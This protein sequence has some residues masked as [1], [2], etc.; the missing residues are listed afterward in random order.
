MRS[1][2]IHR[3]DER[4]VTAVGIV[5]GILAALSPASPTGSG[6]A[7]AVLVA[8]SV[9][10]VVWAGA[11][12]RWWALLA[13]AVVATAVAG[14]LV[15]VAVGACTVLAALWIGTQQRDLSIVR[16]VVAAVSANV[17]IRSDVGW[18]L[19][20]TLFLVA[21]ASAL[22]VVSGLRRRRRAVQRNTA[23]AAAVLG[24][25]VAGTIAASLVAGLTAGSDLR[26][27]VGHVRDGV[28]LLQD[29]EYLAASERFDLAAVELSSSESR[30]SSTWASPASWVP[31]VAQQR[32][33]MTSLAAA[34]ADAS[35]ELAAALRL[36]DPDQLRLVGGRFDLDAIRLIEQP[37]SDVQRSI[38][39]LDA[40]VDRAR[41]PWLVAPIARRL[42]ELDEQLDDNGARL[43]TAVAAVR[44]APQ[45]LGA[46][47]PRRYFLAFTTPTE[48]RGT[49]G[50]MG[51]WAVLTAD[52]GRIRLS[53]FGRTRELNDGG[54]AGRIVSG[55]ADWL[56]QWGRYGFTTG[57]GGSTDS[58]PWSRIT[59]SPV[60][61]STSQVIHE[62]LPQ[63]G[64]RPVDGVFS[65]DPTVLRALLS[66]TGPVSV[67]GSNVRL[68]ESNV[69]Q[70]LLVDQYVTDEV[71]DAG[72][73]DDSGDAPGSGDDGFDSNEERIDFLEDVAQA[74]IRGVLAGALP[75]P[76]VV[77]RE[78]GPVIEQGRLL[79]TA[80]DP[81][82]QELFESI[83]LSGSLPSLDGGDGIAAVFN[84]A[85]PN[86]IDTYLGREFTYTAEVDEQ[87]GVVRSELVLTLTNDADADALPDSVVDNYTGDPR[88][89]NRTLLSLYSALPLVEATVDG[90]PLAMRE[91]AEDGWIVNTA[92]LGIP[93]GGSI[94]VTAQYRGVL[95]LD[96]GYTLA[97]RP[98]PIV[99]PERR[100]VEVTSDR[101]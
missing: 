51:N 33:A 5:G 48:T 24:V 9:G 15:L 17:A 36:V 55:P 10:F 69:L 7:D 40:Q 65:L 34:A 53:E 11:T 62:L 72:N 14:S 77:A 2:R 61:E 58:T 99:V 87:T 52:D 31:V 26:N 18:F 8:A 82:V 56:E 100:T 45:I 6:G 21:G 86:K 76:A 32:N 68:D 4:T 92:F 73:D 101:W 57:P 44:L 30:L 91:S 23:I 74:T 66:L 42:E 75:S 64:R 81:A 25:V 41:S 19:G 88:G 78:L 89:T 29:G 3:V 95:E 84:N 16:A 59:I 49:G 71:T 22:V 85:A 67:D 47:G 43:D 1:T 79:G 97:V 12:A 83:G 13:L 93:P 37:L 39:E 54:E 98:Q 60:F 28:A 27:G 46:D 63:S 96:G 35:D 50:F 80:T 38:D 94:T 70:F 90:R 20:A